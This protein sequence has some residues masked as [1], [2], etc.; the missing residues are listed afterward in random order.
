MEIK[1]TANIEDEELD[2]NKKWVAIDDIKKEIL[3][4]INHKEY[5]QLGVRKATCLD[6]I[7]AK[8][9]EAIK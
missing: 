8:L 4:H 7:Y 1:T 6:V 9:I 5:H 3:K 2:R